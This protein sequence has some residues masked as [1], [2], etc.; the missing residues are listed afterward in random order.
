LKK[1]TTGNAEEGLRR[2]VGERR[3]PA[4][5]PGGEDYGPHAPSVPRSCIQPFY[6]PVRRFRREQTRSKIGAG[7]S[8]RA[9]PDMWKII[10][11]LALIC[12]AFIGELVGLSLIGFKS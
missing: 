10:G 7:E 5:I 9:H 6:L 3:Q 2:A 8:R 11:F 1:R 12:G 4:A